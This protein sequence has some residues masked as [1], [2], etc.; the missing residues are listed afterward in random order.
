M[1]LLTIE[2]LREQNYILDGIQ[3]KSYLPLVMKQ[4]IINNIL[5]VCIIDE[6]KKKIDFSLKLFSLEFN[7]VNQYSNLNCDVDDV[8]KLYDELKEHGVIDGILKQ[9]SESEVKFI[10]N[11]LNEEINQIQVIDNS[12]EVIISNALDKLIEKLPT[13]KEIN[14]MIPKIS[15]ELAKISPETLETFKNV[16][17]D[18]KMVKK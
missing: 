15:K 14:K 2:K 11:V 10:T 16:F 8:I 9:I 18:S 7:L 4:S 17:K 6:N 3:I 12:L 13:S 1:E 5:S